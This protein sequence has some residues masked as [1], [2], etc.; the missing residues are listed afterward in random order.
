LAQIPVERIAMTGT[1]QNEVDKKLAELKN[2][3]DE[4]AQN[5]ISSDPVCAE[6]RGNIAALEWRFE[7]AKSTESGGK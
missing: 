7:V 2:N 5:I 6:I 4:R 3:L 1:T